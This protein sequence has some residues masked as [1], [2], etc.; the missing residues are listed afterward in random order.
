MT[1]LSSPSPSQSQRGAAGK[2]GSD[3]SPTP[4]SEG[5]TFKSTATGTGTDTDDLDNSIDIDIDIDRRSASGAFSSPANRRRSHRDLGSQRAQSPIPTTNSTI[6]TPYSASFASSASP[7]K[8]CVD[9]GSQTDST[10]NTSLSPAHSTRTRPSIS[11]AGGHAYSPP[12]I[13]SI[14]TH[15]RSQRGC[16]VM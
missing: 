14:P 9:A 6:T 4:K 8:W 11:P 5:R 10:I 16:T 12:A 13:P 2:G 7:H 3:R 15:Q 1:S